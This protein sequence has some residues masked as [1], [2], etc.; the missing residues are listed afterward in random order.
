MKAIVRRNEISH[1]Q[2]YFPIGASWLHVWRR[3]LNPHRPL[4][5]RNIR[6][7]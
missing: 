7:K 5:S 1:A 4:C 2:L 6:I 3:T